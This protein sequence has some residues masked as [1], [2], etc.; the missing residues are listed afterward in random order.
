MQTDFIFHGDGEKET[1]N[2]PDEEKD[3]HDEVGVGHPCMTNNTIL[4]LTLTIKMKTNDDDNLKGWVKG[5]AADGRFRQFVNF[6]WKRCTDAKP[7]GGDTCQTAGKG[8][9]T[10]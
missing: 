1:D 4:Q 5:D 8:L 3:E 6:G 9:L 7:V 2:D 10:G